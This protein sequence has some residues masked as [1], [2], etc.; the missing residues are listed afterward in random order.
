MRLARLPLL[1]AALLAPALIA[2]IAHAEAKDKKAKTPVSAAQAQADEIIDRMSKAERAVI[3]RVT[4]F[5]SQRVGSRPAAV[6]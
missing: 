4:A 3:D 5:V 2:S 6:P 1:F